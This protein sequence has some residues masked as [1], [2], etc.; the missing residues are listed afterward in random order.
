MSYKQIRALM[1]TH[2]KQEAACH[3]VKPLS[4]AWT[5]ADNFTDIHSDKSQTVFLLLMR[6]FLL[7]GKHSHIESSVCLER[8]W[9]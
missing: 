7:V 8:S 1:Y 3:I 9:F 5:L 4:A 6:N 2:Q